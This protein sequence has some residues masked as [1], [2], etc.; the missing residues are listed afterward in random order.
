MNSSGNLAHDFI[1]LGEESAECEEKRKGK[2]E[3]QKE[4]RRSTEM[5][6]LAEVK[7]RKTEKKLQIPKPELYDGGRDSTPTY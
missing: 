4:V 7:R 6:M 5:A 1:S 2:K 3:E